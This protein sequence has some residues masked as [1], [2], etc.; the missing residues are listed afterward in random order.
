MSKNGSDDLDAGL[1]YQVDETP[2]TQ[3][4]LG[5]GIQA[6]LL[7]LG[8]T[9]LMPTITFQAAGSSEP[10]VAWAIFA[11]L[12]IA[13]IIS[14]LQAFPF[15][16]FGAGFVLA[17]CPTAAALAVT[18][19]ALSA[20]GPSL[21]LTLMIATALF[22]FVFSYRISMFRRVITQ[23]VSGVILMLIPVTA[24][25]I[26]FQRIGEVSPGNSQ[27]I[28]LACALVTL[29]TTICVSLYA[30]SQLRPWAPLLGICAGGAVA[31]AYGLVDVDQ[32]RQ[33]PWVGLPSTAWP[34]V[35]LDLGPS[36]WALL[37]AF[38]IVAVSC[39]I[40]TMSAALAIQD[41]SW[42]EPRAPD[43]RVV[44]GALAA[45]ALGNLLAG[46]GGTMMNS[47]RS[48][49]VPL[50]KSTQVSARPVG[51]VLGIALVAFAFLPKVAALV[52]ALP[53]AVLAA[54]L[55][56]MLAAL[57]VTG[58]KLVVAEGPDYRRM[59]IIGIS[60]WVGAGC[61]FGL[62]L[63][64]I[65]PQVAGG[66]LDNGLATGGMTAIL[67]TILLELTGHR[68]RKLVTDLDVSCLPELRAF[69]AQFGSD[70]GWSERMRDRLDA[71][72]EETLLTLIE[73]QADSG[74]GSR[75]L[76][77]SAHSEG[78]DAVLEFVAKSNEG[79]IEDRIAFLG[80]ASEARPAERD[81]SLRLLRHLAS[82][83]RHRQY[84][85]LDLIIV[86]VEPLQGAARRSRP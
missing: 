65:L 70:K 84:H 58:M 38:L 34:A 5:L 78:G 79:N 20:G 8:A 85:D 18:V 83:V 86:R 6:A 15:R 49:T 50:V 64:E 33:A 41:A 10:V 59:L 48:S 68:R 47:A 80:D 4:T 81:I 53:P 69:V 54:Y 30:R 11:S 29:A 45:E 31:G 82:E 57:F 7:F 17:T 62:L 71:V 35:G 23:T 74:T 22:Q 32:I 1:L 12:F 60:F 13:G 27:P 28:G 26:M 77:V 14:G 39:S 25:P 72:A 56:I 40:R 43:Q 52:L 3:L 44:Q 51:L 67:M 66:L 2:P 76:W 46:L 42:R 24:V 19:D 9:I 37:P 55:A 21:F 75:R 61:E 73:G 36:F 63:P 16:R